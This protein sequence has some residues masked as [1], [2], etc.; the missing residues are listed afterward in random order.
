MKKPRK[1]TD[2]R[3]NTGKYI[4]DIS[5]LIFGAFFLGGILRL[6]LSHDTIIL[7]GL[8][9]AFLLCIFG[10]IIVSKEKKEDKNE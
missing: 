3:E 4:L 7:G 2:F 5:K 1:R 9:A 8:A 10:L 6:E